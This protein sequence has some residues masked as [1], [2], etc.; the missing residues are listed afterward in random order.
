MSRYW[1]KIANFPYAMYITITHDVEGDVDGISSR[2]FVRKKTRMMG[3]RGDENG[4]F[5]S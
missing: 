2:Y 5:H 3:L 1:W 4:T